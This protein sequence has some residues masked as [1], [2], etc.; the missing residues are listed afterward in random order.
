MKHVKETDKMTTPTDTKNS[1]F[2][3]DNKKLIWFAIAMPLV[4]VLA[5]VAMGLLGKDT[6]SKIKRPTEEVVVLSSS[7]A[8]LQCKQDIYKSCA[9]S[10]RVLFVFPAFNSDRVT[11]ADN[12]VKVCSIPEEKK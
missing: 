8:Y 10:A 4:T 9:S 1:R 7:Q 3:T 6:K 2:N 11:C 12:A 5:L